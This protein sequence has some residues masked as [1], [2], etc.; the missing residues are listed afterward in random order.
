MVTN[1]EI[2]MLNDVPGYFNS[3]VGFNAVRNLFL[4]YGR[5]MDESICKIFLTEKYSRVSDYFKLT[6]EE[7]RE[8][9]VS[10]AW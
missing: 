10:I 8:K 4:K 9:N 2:F 6:E 1:S 5:N 7:V 3:T